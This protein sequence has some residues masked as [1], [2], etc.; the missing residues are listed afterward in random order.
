M[1]KESKITIDDL[2]EL[3]EEEKGGE[4]S[5]FRFRFATIFSILVLNWQ[6]FLLSM[7]IFICG[8]LIYLRYTEPVYQMSARIM[9]K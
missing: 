9:I 6:Y 5:R 8:A 4:V 3:L 7:F 2:E 1:A